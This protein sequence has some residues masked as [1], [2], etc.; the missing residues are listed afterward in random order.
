MNVLFYMRT[1]GIREDDLLRAVA[2]FVS[3]GSLEV[4]ADLESFAG[5]VRRPKDL[6]SVA[7]I[8][9]PTKDDLRALASLRVLLGGGRIL[10]VLPD[11]EEETIALAHRVRPAYITYVDE[12][13]SGVV[14]VL[15]RLAGNAGDTAA[16]ARRR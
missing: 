15:T 7:L 3:R 5:R 1:P 13:I 6:P 14:S 4:F 9:N 11:Q 8:W 16:G 2:P 10:L 12:G